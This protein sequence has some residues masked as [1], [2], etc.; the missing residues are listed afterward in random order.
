VGK[1]FAQELEQLGTTYSWARDRDPKNIASMI[2]GSRPVPLLAVGSGGSLSAAHFAAH[3]HRCFEKQMAKAATP[4]EIFSDPVPSKC[5]ALLLTAQGRNSD[6]LAAFKSLLCSQT[7]DVGIF[8]LAA[9]SPLG[10]LARGRV[11]VH[12]DEL[13]LPTGKD[14]FLATNSLLAFFVL[15]YKL[16]QF[17]KP[18]E[19]LPKDIQALRGGNAITLLDAETRKRCQSLAK[20]E[21]LI[22]IY[23]A[24][25]QSAAFDLESKFSEA[26]LGS[27]HFADLRNFAHG[28]H[29]WIAKRAKTSGVLILVSNRE[30]ALA[31]RTR[32]LLPKSTETV[33]LKSSFSGPLA[34]ISA[35]VDVL[36]FVAIAGQM[37]GIDPGKPGVPEFGRKIY[38]LRPFGTLLHPPGQDPQADAIELKIR[39]PLRRLE[40][41][42][43]KFWEDQYHRFLSRLHLANF[44]G[45]VLD[46][47]GT[48]CDRGNRYSGVGENV[49]EALQ[50]IL[51]SRVAVGIATG[52]GK[53]VAEDFR[54]KLPR[55]YWKRILVGYYNGAEIGTLA[56]KSCPEGADICSDE[57][58][59]VLCRLQAYSELMGIASLTVRKYQ[60]TVESAISDSMGLWELVFSIVMD[61]FPRVQVLRSTH[62]VDILASSTSKRNVLDRL[63]RD[64]DNPQA[65]FLCI[66]DL[67]NWPGN[68]FSLLREPYSLSVDQV[69]MDPQ[70]C[71][72]LNRSG[73]RGSEATVDILNALRI[74]GRY[75]KVDLK[76]LGGHSIA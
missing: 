70:S 75:F 16:Y 14:G 58:R 55:K 29:H 76:S 64:L 5:V 23:G 53:S 17:G 61:F 35:L 60:I 3:L 51:E 62:S 32:E 43:L 25:T 46:Y 9:Q 38:H 20:K 67:G 63:R 39:S 37:R 19:E 10:R 45:L 6:I 12:L 52:R 26:A 40:P 2:R 42:R 24:D 65:D 31:Q 21:T 34:S 49:L 8:C 74:K 56:D 36:D 33:I 72:K 59:P 15:L 47:D 1:P 11:G 30:F 44:A 68:D 57:L 73:R 18:G 7:S 48:L 66:G 28:R 13:I 41:V 54:K 27:V 71:W 4:L 50:Q 22:V 69:S